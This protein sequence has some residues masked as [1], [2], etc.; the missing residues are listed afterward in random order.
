MASEAWLGGSVRRLS[1]C[2]DSFDC[3]TEDAGMNPVDRL[4]NTEDAPIFV[5]GMPRSGTT[6]IQHLL[7]QHPRIQIHG[8]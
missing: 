3:C 4:P 5:T 7:S 1:G 2:P 8:Q 6:F